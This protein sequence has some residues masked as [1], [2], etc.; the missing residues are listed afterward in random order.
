[1]TA[2]NTL[3]YS[4]NLTI[5][6]DRDH[7]PDASVDLIYLDP[8]FNSNRSYNVLF[9]DESGRDSDAQITAFEDQLALGPQHR[10]PLQRPRDRRPHQRRR[11]Q[12]LQR[13]W[14]FTVPASVVT[15]L[16]SWMIPFELEEAAVI[17]GCTQWQAFACVIAPVV[18]PGLAA[19]AAL[20]LLAQRHMI[21]GLAVAA[22]KA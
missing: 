6:R 21:R 11:G 14:R 7:F 15:R 22:V 19:M 16:Q 10:R 20:V 4:D 9:R 3:F 17:D 18:R 5:L 1:M 12:H 13:L 2:P 8:P